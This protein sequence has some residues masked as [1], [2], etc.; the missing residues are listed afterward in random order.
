MAGNE[1]RKEQVLNGAWLRVEA[2]DFYSRGSVNFKAVAQASDLASSGVFPINNLVSDRGWYVAP[3]SSTINESSSKWFSKFKTKSSLPAGKLPLVNGVYFQSGNYTIDQNTIPTALATT[4]NLAAVIF[5]ESDLTINKD[6]SLDKTSGYV[7]VMGKDL[8]TYKN[9]DNIAGYYIVDG[10]IDTG[11][12]GN[13]G[14]QLKVNGGLVGNGDWH[15]GKSLSANK[16]LT[17][18]AEVITF[19]INYFVNRNLIN[20]ITGGS[21]FIWTEVAP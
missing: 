8:R 1:A 2:G 12:N 18:P 6:F 9:V 21:K 15:L 4:Q 19:P 16:N 20:L 14:E 11:Y 5:I 3:Y 10:K 17:T 7:F 13:D